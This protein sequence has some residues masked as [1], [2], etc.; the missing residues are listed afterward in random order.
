MRDEPTM[1]ESRYIPESMRL[2][3]PLRS[4]MNLRRVA[5]ELRGLAYRLETLSK[6]PR[7]T[8]EATLF[9]A[10]QAVYRANKNIAR[11]RYRGRPRLD[12]LRAE[13]TRSGKW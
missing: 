4:V 3:L 13:H 7:E 2:Q 1:I 10:S 5:E 8:T 11:I 6:Y 12:H 9:E